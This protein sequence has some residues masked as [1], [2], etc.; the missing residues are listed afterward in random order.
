LSQLSFADKIV[1]QLGKDPAVLAAAAALVAAEKNFNPFNV[2]IPVICSDKSLP[3]TKE[4]RGILPKVDPAV[5]G[6]DIENKNSA[7][8]L[9]TP[10]DATNLSVAEIIVLHG[11]SNFTTQDV[12]GKT[13]K[14]SDLAGAG[15]AAANS[16]SAD[17]TAT[18]AANAAVTTT[19]IVINNCAGAATAA[20]SA[21]VE[22]AAAVAGAGGVQKSTV[23]GLD[24]GKC[25][26]TVKFEAGL[27]GRKDTE[28]TFQAIDGLVNKGQQEALNPGIIFN[29]IC[30]QLTNVCGANQAAKDACKA[31]QSQLSGGTR[32]KALADSWNTQLGFAGTNTNP[33]NAPQPGLV[34][35]T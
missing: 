34:G 28:F 24:F 33:D 30:D 13:G 29:R 7:D 8:S 6:S 22:T 35:H 17:A 21:A 2:P 27:N 18:A 4:L 31:A 15:S 1:A 12:A 25:V 9:T 11:F 5:I 16:G 10:F 3:A 26:P 23:A 32:N 19:T 14:A 20:A